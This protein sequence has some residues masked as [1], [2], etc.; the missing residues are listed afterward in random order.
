[1]L[2]V[3]RSGGTW[4][5][6]ADTHIGLGSM[7]GRPSEPPEASA[8]KMALSLLGTARAVS[9]KG[10]LHL[11]DV[12]EPI[13][14][15]PAPMR[16]AVFRFFATLLSGGLE[17]ELVLGNHDVGLV[18][19]LPQEVVVHPPSG[20]VRFG[21]GLF[22]GHR[23]PSMEVLGARCLVVGHLHP[24][25]R[26]A[27]TPNGRSG[28]QRCWIRVRFPRRRTPPR[29]SKDPRISARELIVLPPFNPIAGTEALNVDRPARGRAFLYRHFIAA[30]EVRAYL[31][32]G[33]DLGNVIRLPP[34]SPGA[35]YGRAPRGW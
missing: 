34:S 12:K 30:G 20:T 14:G 26:L 16:S 33:T 4:L 29:R 15:T 28:K 32:D 7:P 25:V 24:G 35:E 27:T 11:G 17:T 3:K 23:W 8:E 18:R 21:I 19:H 2:E 6:V 13:L 31:L 5:L 1:M 22:H 10:V 9:A